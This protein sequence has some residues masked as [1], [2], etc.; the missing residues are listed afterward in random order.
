M[1]GLIAA[2]FMM[3]AVMSPIV[4]ENASAATTSASYK[5]LVYPSGSTYYVKNANGA[6]VY[7]STNAASAIQKAIDSLTSGRTTKETVL[8]RERLL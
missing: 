4:T 6:V 2:S 1:V 7:S 3:M 8:L 5:Y